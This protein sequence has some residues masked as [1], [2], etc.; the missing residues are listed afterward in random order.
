MQQLQTKSPLFVDEQGYSGNIAEYNPNDAIRI[1][2]RML[3]R[4]VR[5]AMTDVRGPL[6]AGEAEQFILDPLIQIAHVAYPAGGFHTDDA[7]DALTLLN[8]RAIQYA[9]IGQVLDA[10]QMRELARYLS[11]DALRMTPM[12][13]AIRNAGG[14]FA[15]WAATG[16]DVPDALNAFQVLHSWVSGS[17]Q[18][19]YAATRANNPHQ[20]NFDDIVNNVFTPDMNNDAYA[21]SFSIM[22][23][24]QNRRTVVDLQDD[25][26]LDQNQI[27]ALYDEVLTHAFEG[28]GASL[29]PEN[30]AI[31]QDK[32]T[33]VASS[34]QLLCEQAETLLDDHARW[35]VI[36]LAAVLTEGLLRYLNIVKE[37][38]SWFPHHNAVMS[39]SSAMSYAKQRVDM[40]ASFWFKLAIIPNSI[41][42]SVARA[43]WAEE[44]SLYSFFGQPYEV[45]TKANEIL[46]AVS[47]KWDE[48]ADPFWKT[49]GSLIIQELK[50]FT[51]ASLL[52]SRDSGPL[53]VFT[54]WINRIVDD[55]TNNVV[56]AGHEDE[57]ALYDRLL[58]SAPMEIH[59][60]QKYQISQNLAI[61]ASQ[62]AD[63][64]VHAVHAVAYL[65]L[66]ADDGVRIRQDVAPVDKSMWEMP[67]VQPLS[68]VAYMTFTEPPALSAA[69][70]KYLTHEEQSEV[71]ETS[72]LVRRQVQA[73]EAT[74]RW[75]S[76]TFQPIYFNR[77]WLTEASTSA[78][79]PASHIMWDNTSDI[80]VTP[81][82]LS[83]QYGY[84]PIPLCY[85]SDRN[86]DRHSYSMDRY[87][88]TQS[89]RV[90]GLSRTQYL[91]NVAALA[92]RYGGASS[93]LRGFLLALS[94][95][96]FVYQADVV[97][98][99]DSELSNVQWLTVPNHLVW[100]VP[101][102]LLE[103]A[104]RMTENNTFQPVDE[105][106]AATLADAPNLTFRSDQQ[107]SDGAWHAF[108]FILHRQYPAATPV[109]FVIDEPIP[110]YSY[111]TPMAATLMN[112]ANSLQAAAGGQRTVIA[113]LY[114]A[115]PSTYVDHITWVHPEGWSDFVR[116]M[117]GVFFDVYT[118]TA[119]IE[120]LI[121]TSL[122]K[123][124]YRV[125]PFTL[126][127]QV[128]AFVNDQLNILDYEDVVKVWNSEDPII[129]CDGV[130]FGVA[131]PIWD[132][133]GVRMT[134]S[135]NER[136]PKRIVG[137]S[138]DDAAANAS[139]TLSEATP[140]VL[141][142]PAANVTGATM[143]PIGH[144]AAP[145]S[146]F[147]YG[148]EPAQ[149]TAGDPASSNEDSAAPAHTE[150]EDEVWVVESESPLKLV[151]VKKSKV[152][153]NSRLAS[154]SEITEWL[155]KNE[156]S[157]TSN[158]DSDEGK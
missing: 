128:R 51:G 143:Q 144:L 35:D 32:I 111:L 116:Y 14:A 47:E 15:D 106:V 109:Q 150:E 114:N 126:G 130:T 34:I 67:T 69:V 153:P 21:L 93:L 64:M 98:P 26:L 78:S 57:L 134:Y 30:R 68:D 139:R 129:D 125:N 44:Q 149:V 62:L 76:R 124:K 156:M 39:S 110:G 75:R 104:Q 86:R 36:E 42:I 22:F 135:P 115:S 105:Y 80:N 94:N 136:D 55:V 6:Y 17:A 157:Q 73:N 61:M 123:V 13:R 28:K 16:A 38:E 27:Q 1:L 113:Q 127:L 85:T 118:R 147:Q 158:S 33:S 90:D 99:G 11:D 84:Q 49:M 3:Q 18:D 56:M 141:T 92:A 65:T 31:T 152:L 52:L 122:I 50:T 74:W 23:S 88:R 41:S 40:L 72:E 2:S 70:P 132:D 19:V 112:V 87:L 7:V 10:E 77:S 142:N 66:G 100:A 120:D 155:K 138:S 83:A 9:L 96:I 137:Q 48:M 24:L 63:A 81:D 154:K 102:T 91:E 140:V 45:Y 8:S 108:I 107:D 4:T 12:Y 29:L 119:R 25:T 59:I 58:P 146:V 82:V 97:N 133:S 79:S 121:R 46:N 54:Q 145:A 101:S 103:A 151:K 37:Y 148:V 71:A 20:Q 89:H 95:S 117:P 53:A 5:K 131:K 60:S 43:L